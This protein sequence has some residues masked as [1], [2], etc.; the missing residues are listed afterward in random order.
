MADL[1]SIFGGPFTLAIKQEA[2]PIE[3]QIADAMQAAGLTPPHPIVIDGKLHRFRAGTKGQGGHGDKS[4][5]YVI[6]PDGIP[7]GKFGCWRAGIEC[8]WRAEIGRTLTPVEEMAHARRL[9]EAKAARDAELA[10]SREVAASTVDQIWTNAMPATAEHPYLARKGV[11]PHGARLTGDGRLVVPLYGTDGELSSLQYIDH[12]GGKLYHPGGATGGK[13]WQIGTTD[14]LGP[15]YL[16]EGFATAATI[17]EATGRPCI[18]AYSA[19]NLVPVCGAIRERFGAAQDLVIVADHDAS[20]TGQKYADQASAKYGARVVMP[21]EP[22]DANDYAQ[23]GHDLRAL[24]MPPAGQN[25]IEKLQVVFG[26]ELGAEYEPPDELVEGLLTL[27]SLSVLY[28]DSNSGKTFF[29]L[30]LAT[31]I[32]TGGACFGRKVDQGL[33]LYLASEAPGSIRS[34][35]QAL[36]KHHKCDLRRLAM[37]PV[38]LNFYVGDGDVTDVYEVVKFIEQDRGEPVRLIIG[39]TLARMSA[40][41]NE[42]SG[43]DM[44]P[45][46]ARFDRLAQ[47]TGAAVLIIHHSGKDQARGARGWSGIRA[48][49][50]TEIEVVEKDGQRTASI[51]KQR[52]LPSKGEDIA[53]KLEVVEMGTTKFGSPA[54]TC[55]ALPDDSPRETKKPKSESKVEANRKLFERAWFA[56]G[57][58]FRD[59]KPYLSRAGLKFKLRED[60]VSESMIEKM[61]KP[62]KP[63]DLIGSLLAADIIEATEHGWIVIA[64]AHAA[65]MRLKSAGPSG[66]D[67]TFPD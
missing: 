51:T 43:E 52:E 59:E 22:G 39:D 60:G 61:L 12:N 66:P 40:G 48:H 65:A 27:A 50:D 15:I 13:F 3:H 24:L 47:A 37:V 29:A 21:P 42:N 19:S 38:P 67:R 23:A 44:G 17:H 35:M 64:E 34:R 46:M 31:A 57:A 32:A 58:E 20:G 9:T 16:A 53:F 26:N 5:W 49:I 62:G 18:V 4:G 45:V 25:A 33:V 8:N 41:A 30:S 6:Y 1:V 63:Q 10:K 54:T 28:G 11:Q 7:A 2:P 36:K 14:E 55:V 56:A